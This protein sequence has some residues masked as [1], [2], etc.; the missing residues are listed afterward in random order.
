V[1]GVVS[2]TRASVGVLVMLSGV[3]V[4][5]PYP[6]RRLNVEYAVFCLVNLKK[7]V[8]KR[9]DDSLETTCCGLLCFRRPEE[10][11]LWVL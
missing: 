4:M 7:L 6:R 1:G 11:E 10:F 3:F 2:E 5:H 8:K 9:G